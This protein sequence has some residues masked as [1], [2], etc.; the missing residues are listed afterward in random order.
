MDLNYNNGQE[1]YARAIQASHTDSH[2]NACEQLQRLAMLYHSRG[3]V[4]EAQ[5]IYELMRQM[6][7]SRAQTGQNRTV[8]GIAD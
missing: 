8:F 3:R 5:E 7:N 1:N 6:I 4:V 2:G